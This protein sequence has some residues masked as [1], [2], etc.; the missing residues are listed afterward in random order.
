MNHDGWE[1]FNFFLSTSHYWRSVNFFFY[2][3]LFQIS[4]SWVGP[5]THFWSTWDPCQ[6][7]CSTPTVNTRSSPNNLNGTWW[8]RNISTSSSPISH[9]WR[10]VN[11]TV[12]L[13]ILFFFFQISASCV[14]SRTNWWCSCVPRQPCWST[15][16]TNTH[17][18]RDLVRLDCRTTCC[19]CQWPPERSPTYWCWSWCCQWPKRC[20]CERGIEHLNSPISR[21]PILYV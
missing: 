8:V 15:P 17:M 12:I 11:F 7:C 16:T 2:L 1:S 6:H 20:N 21:K 5:R 18:Q 9:Y 10:C 4:A 19:R 3:F 13:T 14:S